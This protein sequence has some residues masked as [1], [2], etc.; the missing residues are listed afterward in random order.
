MGRCELFNLYQEIAGDFEDD[1]ILIMN[2]IVAETSPHQHSY[3]RAGKI[4]QCNEYEK[5]CSNVLMSRWVMHYHKMFRKK[6]NLYDFTEDQCQDI[7]WVVFRRVLNSFNLSMLSDKGAE[8]IL[9]KY[10]FLSIKTACAETARRLLLY[11]STVADT[12][13]KHKRIRYCDCKAV[14][15][16]DC[17]EIEDPETISKNDILYDISAHIEDNPY[18]KKVLETILNLGD[19]KCNV[20]AWEIYKLMDISESERSNPLTRKYVNS[21]FNTIKDIVGRYR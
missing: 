7:I 3:T 6:F 21:A 1:I 10:V 20:E 13:Q 5:S 8:K 9:G 11:E 18:G 16:D 19:K 14:D 15:S 17:M 12:K 2:Q 4:F